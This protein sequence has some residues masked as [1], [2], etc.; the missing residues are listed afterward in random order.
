MNEV[1]LDTAS[2]PPAPRP[3]Y[4]G[5]ADADGNTSDETAETSALLG[6]ERPRKAPAPLSLAGHAITLSDMDECNAAAA[7]IALPA[8]PPPPPRPLSTS[9]DS[10]DLLALS[11]STRRPS[12]SRASSH[13]GSTTLRRRPR[14]SAARPLAIPAS[15]APSY[16]TEFRQRYLS[17]VR[18]RAMAEALAARL[19]PSPGDSDD[20]S[21]RSASSSRS[22]SEDSFGGLSPARSA[23]KRAAKRGDAGNEKAPPAAKQYRPMLPRR[24]RIFSQM[25]KTLAVTSLVVVA[26]LVGL[27]L[28]FAATT[29]FA[30]TFV[31]CAI[32]LILEST[33]LVIPAVIFLFFFV[34]VLII[35][36]LSWLGLFGLR[37]GLDSCSLIMNRI[38]T[39]VQH[40]ADVAASIVNL[41]TITSK[42]RAAAPSPVPVSVPGPARSQ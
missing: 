37:F 11:S 36:G 20:D 4:D 35:L 8:T 22:S 6:G 38:L 2:L 1:A 33:I 42:L 30:T 23:R 12:S 29:L 9:D 28:V 16:L 3:G 34:V 7:A 17:W 18:W 13:R 41:S 32:M 40:Y 27:F 14:F 24:P 5:D 10:D 19:V 39:A 31:G 26:A 25:R 21:V 15:A